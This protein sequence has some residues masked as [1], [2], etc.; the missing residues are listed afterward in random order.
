M[1]SPLFNKERR[2]KGIREILS[3]LP[4]L[5]ICLCGCVSTTELDSKTQKAIDQV[6]QVMTNAL[7]DISPQSAVP[8]LQ[9]EAVPRTAV[10]VLSSAQ[11]EVELPPVTND[12]VLHFDYQKQ[13]TNCWLQQS[14]DFVNWMDA[15]GFQVETNVDGSPGWHIPP[16]ANPCVFY[17]VRGELIP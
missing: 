5:L 6:D 14:T 12:L 10:R 17:R 13:L 2:N 16:P 4:V 15:S 7:P 1:N 3:C 11:P 8:S 9:L